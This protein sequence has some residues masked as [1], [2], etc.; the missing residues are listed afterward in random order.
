MNDQLSREIY[1]KIEILI[2]EAVEKI[3]QATELADEH[4]LSFSLNIDPCLLKAT[5]KGKYIEDRWESSNPNCEN[6]RG[7]WVEFEYE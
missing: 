3:E 6:N 5:Y 7:E 2:K 4:G 1:S